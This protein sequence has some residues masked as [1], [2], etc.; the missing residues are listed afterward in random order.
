[1][2]QASFKTVNLNMTKEE[3]ALRTTFISQKFNTYNKIRCIGIT[4]ATKV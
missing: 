2:L 3:Q 4:D 1:M